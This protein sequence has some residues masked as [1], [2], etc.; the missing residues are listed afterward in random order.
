MESLDEFS[1]IKDYFFGLSHGAA[2]VIGPG[3]D[4]AVLRLPIGEELATSSDTLIEGSHF[5]FGSDGD[6]IAY[7]A[8]ATSASD[9]AA[10]GA[11]PLASVLSVSL[12][13]IDTAWLEDFTQGLAQAVQ[14]FSLPLVG[15]DLTAGPLSITV[16][17]YGSLPANHGLLRSGA[18]P[19]ETVLVSGTL[20]DAAAGLAFLNNEWEPDQADREFLARRFFRP[21]SRL[22]L[23]SSLLKIASAAID[24]SDGLLA[25]VG[26]IASA[27]SLS[28]R[29][30]ARKIPLSPALSKLENSQQVLEWA[31]SGGDDYELC[32]TMPANKTVPSGCTVIGFT[33]SGNGVSCDGVEIIGSRKGYRHF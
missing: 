32:F 33:T 21:E 18:R 1:V 11:Q 27:S 13:V 10:M 17:V 4:C 19:G 16:T 14:C 20:G 26:H 31:L 5:P 8:I 6:D 3:D 29:I 9:L 15:G 25:D 2:T 28:I 30:D 23:A 7:R 22:N 24:I 12:P